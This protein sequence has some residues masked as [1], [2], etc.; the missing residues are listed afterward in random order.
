MKF[1]WAGKVVV[2]TGA[3]SGIGRAL[4]LDLKERGARLALNDWNADALEETRRLLGNADVMTQTFSVADPQAWTAFRD[5]AMERFGA[6][7][8]LVNNAGIGH[9]A[10]ATADMDP[11]DFARVLDVNLWGT[12][13]GCQAFLSDLTERPQ[14]A[15]VNVSSIYGSIAVGLL[16]AYC[17][18]KFAVR[19]FTESLRMEARAFHPNLLVSVVQPGGIATNVARNGISAG[20]RTTD[21]RERDRANFEKNLKTSSEKAARTIL[22][23]VERGRER[24]LIGTDAR[25][26]DA[27][28]RLRPVGYT[29]TVLGEMKRADLVGSEPPR[30][31]DSR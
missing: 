14:A 11:A 30:K 20:S 31:L 29:N 6:V 9:E 25:I 16:N 21:E 19:G 3:G 23:G 1:D 8:G 15:L 17:T 5:E 28:G 26:A 2:L 13:H 4:A 12:I 24:I 27:M 22:D 10:V 7:D 18:S